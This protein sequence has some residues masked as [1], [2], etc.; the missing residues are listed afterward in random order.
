MIAATGAVL[1]VPFIKRM[2]KYKWAPSLQDRRVEQG[3][4]EA[5]AEG[6]G[7]GQGA[8]AVLEAM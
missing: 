3:T 6:G 7:V 4:K 8:G 1:H 5:R 2:V